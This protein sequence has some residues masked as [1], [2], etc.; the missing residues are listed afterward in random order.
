L[1]EESKKPQSYKW[2]TMKLKDGS[3]A[4]Y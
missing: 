4:D 1:A 3:I 2:P